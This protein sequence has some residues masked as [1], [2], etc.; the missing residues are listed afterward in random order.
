VTARTGP[1]AGW[2]ATL[3]TGRAAWPGVTIA[4]EAFVAHVTALVPDAEARAAALAGPYAGDLYLAAAV[5]AGASG[6]A[7]ALAGG[8][9]QAIGEAVRA[10][11]G[12]DAIADELASRVLVRVIGPRGAGADAPAGAIT[13]YAGRAPLRAWLRVIA[14]REAAKLVNAHRRASGSGDDA[15]IAALSPDVGPELAYMKQLY[16]DEVRAAFTTALA[17][18]PDKQ[19]LLLRQ[20]VVDELTIDQIAPLHAV[21]RSTIARW[22]AAARD[23]L[24][25]AT[26]GEL[27]RRLAVPAAEVDSILR[28]VHSR[29]E[30]SLGP[31]R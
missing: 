26:R 15:L 1:D 16:R 29:L 4:D 5:A 27:A 18:L 12:A 28:L 30:I 23:D 6:A 14:V 25:R 11:R 17:G 31:I 20:A 24:A 21:G 9:A 19:R 10:I 22:L 13:G 2:A 7:E 3:A 8:V